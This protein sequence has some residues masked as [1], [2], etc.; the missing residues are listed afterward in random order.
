MEC[1][2]Q[3]AAGLHVWGTWIYFTYP[4]ALEEYM[5]VE[6]EWKNASRLSWVDSNVQLP[7]CN[8]DLKVTR[9]S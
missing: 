4:S 7:W 8:S 6:S 3:T 5:L 9:I 1:N 2:T